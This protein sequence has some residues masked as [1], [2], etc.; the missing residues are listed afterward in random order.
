MEKKAAGREAPAA[1]LSK[2]ERRAQL[3]ETAL[4]MVREEGTDGLTLAAVAERAGVTKPIAYDHFGTRSG[5]LIALYRLLDERQVEALRRALAVAPRQLA[6]VARVVAQAHVDCCA[7]GGEWLAVSAALKGDEAME[8]VQ[9]EL[10]DGC[11]ALYGRAFGPY[12]A[13]TGERL[14]LACVGIL[15]AGEAIGAEVVRGRVAEAAAV[16][17]FTQLI[18]ASLANP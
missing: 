14:R 8:A 1:R 17:A 4:A 11:I 16:S 12:T 9:R 7:A 18:V 3:L 5:L 6:E 13:L 10:V 15:G 2:G